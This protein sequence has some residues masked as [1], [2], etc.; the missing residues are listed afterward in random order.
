MEITLGN[1]SK[2]ETRA[3][4]TFGDAIKGVP[5]MDAT[6]LGSPIYIRTGR[7]STYNGGNA[8]FICI[9]TNGSVNTSTKGR[10]VPCTIS[11]ITVKL[12][13]ARK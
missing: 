7:G 4:H 1:K 13:V 8:P 9:Q 6:D 2:C 11:E 5:F 3:I 12:T 10:R